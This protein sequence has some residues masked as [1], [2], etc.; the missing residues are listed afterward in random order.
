MKEGETRNMC[1]WGM[2]FNSRGAKRAEGIAYAPF[3][4]KQAQKPDPAYAPIDDS[5]LRGGGE[6][7]STGSRPPR[8]MSDGGVI[9]G[10]VIGVGAFGAAA[11]CLCGRRKEPQNFSQLARNNL[12]EPLLDGGAAG[13]GGVQMGGVP[14]AAPSAASRKMV[15][16]LFHIALG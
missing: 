4:R 9:A 5:R 12:N 14:A 16:T 8:P 1:Q 2:Q 3:L 10:V 13:A 15:H 11:Y 7:Q 6:A